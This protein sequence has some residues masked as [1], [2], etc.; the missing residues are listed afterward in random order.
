MEGRERF[1]DLQ[2]VPGKLFTAETRRREE[3]AKEIWVNR[4]DLFVEQEKRCAFLAPLCLRG[5]K[6]SLICN[7]THGSKY[8]LIRIVITNLV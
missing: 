3:D 5:L 8:S 1:L 6:F 7:V 2:Q 4:V